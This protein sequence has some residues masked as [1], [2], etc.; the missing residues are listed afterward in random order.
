MCTEQHSTPPI[1]K[2]IPSPKTSPRSS[3]SS[4]HPYRYVKNPT[5]LRTPL[6]N[7][8]HHLVD[9]VLRTDRFF[10]GSPLGEHPSVSQDRSQTR[11]RRVCAHQPSV[12]AF[13]RGSAWVG[14]RVR[15]VG[16]MP[17]APMPAP[18]KSK[19]LRMYPPAFFSLSAA[20]THHFV[21][22]YHRT[23]QWP[24]DNPPY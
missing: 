8:F 7:R 1:N 4:H 15:V 19:R 13:L 10:V 18:P 24:A 16:W 22:H 21:R 23:P 5:P 20:A 3:G 2:T 12:G 17:G 9:V 6:I 11:C 14:V